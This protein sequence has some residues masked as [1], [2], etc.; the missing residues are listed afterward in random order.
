MDMELIYAWDVRKIIA[1]IQKIILWTHSNII[2]TLVVL[3]CFK[4]PYLAYKLL[5]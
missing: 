3:K 1:I 2:D 5:I 4:I